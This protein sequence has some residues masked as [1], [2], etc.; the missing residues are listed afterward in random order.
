MTDYTQLVSRAE[1]L[2]TKL[3][4]ILPAVPSLPDWTAIAW[5]WQHNKGHG[6][7]EVI[8]YPHLITLDDL[9]NIDQQ[10]AE[11]VRNTAQF[12]QGYT[13]N[14]V[15]L[16]G[17]RGTGKSSIVKALLSQFSQNGLRVVEVDKQDLIDLP[18]ITALLRSRPERFIVFCDDLSF[19]AGDSGYKALK[20]VLDGSMTVT[21]DNI[22]VYA[23]SNRRH[24]LPEFMTESLETQ[25][26][27]GEVRPGD[28]VEE[29]TSLSDRF[30]MWLSFYSFDQD[31]YL[32]VAAQWLRHYGIQEFSEAARTAALQWSHTRGSRSG[33]AAYQF[34]RDYAGRKMLAATEVSKPNMFDNEP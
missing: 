22:L 15:L 3:E 26:L 18:Q 2:L 23:T 27:G 28:T 24:L 12:V 16:T 13:A 17:A 20:V 34:A 7:L 31:E 33:R 14:N 25:H 21:A 1:S 9:Y 19:E 29:K 5:R 6:Y 11:I 10:K 30:G 32:T 4:A 8:P